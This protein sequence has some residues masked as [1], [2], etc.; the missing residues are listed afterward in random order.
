MTVAAVPQG[1]FPATGEGPMGGIFGMGATPKGLPPAKQTTPRGNLNDSRHQ[2]N[3]RKLITGGI[4]APKTPTSFADLV[5][6]ADS[7]W[8]HLNLLIDL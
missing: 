8:Q 5:G 6:Y 7:T 4:A 1:G 2:I 3:H